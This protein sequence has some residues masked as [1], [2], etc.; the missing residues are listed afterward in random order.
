MQH[1]PSNVTIAGSAVTGTLDSC[2]YT[3]CPYSPLG[4]G[5][6]IALPSQPTDGGVPVGGNDAEQ[7]PVTGNPTHL[8]TTSND[9]SGHGARYWSNETIDQAGEYYT[10]KITGM[11][12]F[13]IGLGS[14]DDGDRAEMVSDT[15]TA[16]SGLLWGM[17]SYPW[18]LYCTLDYIW[19]LS[20]QAYGPGGNGEQ[21]EQ[22]RYNTNVQDAHDI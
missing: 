16:A 3:K 18:K 4:G 12:R 20:D 8:L 9:T 22:Y 7:V 11:G 13:I 17:L 10:V 2:Q 5:G 1:Q 15:G 14:E 21:T 19:F 6:S